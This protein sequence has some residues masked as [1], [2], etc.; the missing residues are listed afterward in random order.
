MF[1]KPFHSLVVSGRLPSVVACLGLLLAAGAPAV[2]ARQWTFPGVPQP[3]EA[4][5]VAMKDG[6]VVLKGPNGK[7]FEVPFANFSPADQKYLKALEANGGVPPVEETTGQPVTSPTGYKK[8][9]VETLTNQTV[10]LAGP[11]ELHITGMG[12]PIAGSS[13]NF[14]TPDAWLFFDNILPSVVESKFVSRMKVSGAKAKSGVNVRVVQYGQGAVVIPHEPD[15][16]AMTICDG[17]DLG[18]TSI[19]LKCYTEYNSARL[20]KL[21]APAAS[22]VLKRGY[23]ATLAQNEKGTGASRNYVAQDHDI[24]VDGLPPGLDKGVQ[25]VRVFPWRWTSKKGVAGGI[26]DKLNVGWFYDWNIGAKSSPDLEYVAIKQKRYWPGMDQDWKEKGINHLLGFNEP[27]RPDQA[28]MTVD[29]AIAGWP[30]LLGTGLRLGSPAVSDGGLGWLYEFIDKADS[31]GLRV[32]YVAVHY[33]RAVNDPK[34][35]KGAASQ[36][37][38]FIKGIHERTKR[39]I[40]ITEW[41]NGANWTKAPDPDAEQQ[42]DAI[43]KMIKM[44]DETPFVER[45]AIYNWVESVRHVRNDDGFLTPA[46]QVYRDKVSPV[47]FTQPKSEK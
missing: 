5:F 46:G 40:W 32:D 23:M 10:E 31:A 15:F 8:K 34:D 11:S 1:K 22:F 14:S 45:Y 13:F 21:K 18:G 42:K 47:F 7:S 19:P 35:A 6:G 16:P 24:V 20:G 2:F 25:V 38:G 9:S 12:D 28:K 29:E 4:E 36:F 37:Y 17:K 39:P 3:L 41:N 33:Y 30:E 27:D 44:L 43:E 26:W